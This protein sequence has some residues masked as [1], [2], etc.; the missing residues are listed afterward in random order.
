MIG[1]RRDPKAPP[2]FLTPRQITVVKDDAARFDHGDGRWI[3]DLR[4]RL[5][6]TLLEETGLRLSEALLL[7]HHDW[8]PGTGTTAFLEVQPRE[9]QRRRLRVKNQKYRRVY[10]SDDLDDLYSEYLFLLVELGL[11]V[12]DTD[13]VFVNLFRSEFGRPVRAETI[14]DWIAGFKRRHPLLPSGWT[15]HW[16]RHSHATALLLAGVPEHVVQRRL[17]HSDFHTLMATYAHVTEDAAMRAAAD[18][19]TLVARWGAVA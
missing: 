6:W 7:Q 1:R 15:P 4:L 18:W 19:K 10:L 16:F 5:F 11:D 14:Y 9:D 12:Q 13:P 2:P 8:Q 3:G 17:G